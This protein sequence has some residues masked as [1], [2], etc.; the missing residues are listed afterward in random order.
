MLSQVV[1]EHPILANLPRDL[2]L[3]A[4]SNLRITLG[5]R[6]PADRNGKPSADELNSVLR[7]N[8]RADRKGNHLRTFGV[9]ELESERCLGVKRIRCFPFTFDKFRGSNQLQYVGIIPTETNSGIAFKD[10]DLSLPEHRRKMW[11]GRIE[12]LF[13]CIFHDR[14]GGEAGEYDLAFISCL[15][16][17]RSPSALGPLQRNAGARLFY[18]PKKPWTIVVPINRILGRV[19][20]MRCYLAGSSAPTIPHSMARERKWFKY[21]V[22]DRAGH[23]GSGSKVFELNV[24]LWEFGRPQPR[25]MTVRE[26]LERVEQ[27]KAAAAAKRTATWSAKKKA[28]TARA[29]GGGEDAQLALG[30]AEPVG[31]GGARPAG[32]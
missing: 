2:A 12:L 21:G 31:A 19:P 4:Y 17:L 8:L 29:D 32:I 23:V 20:L 11:V 14:V 18:V 16:E 10:F 5:L 3:F 22:A 1:L 15:Y 9:L 6:P 24:H 26:R 7:F 28:R 13:S 30:A 25:T 27:A